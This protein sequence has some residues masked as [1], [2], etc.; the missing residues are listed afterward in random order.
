MSGNPF[1][2]QECGSVDFQL[3]NLHSL[4]STYCRPTVY[5][6]YRKS[7]YCVPVCLCENPSAYC[8]IRTGQ[9]SAHP[10]SPYLGISQ[11]IFKEPKSEFCDI[12]KILRNSAMSTTEYSHVN[13]AGKKKN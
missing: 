10:L 9:A 11:Q 6:H 7:H 5:S 4:P 8:Q 2:C 13:H 1:S 3:D 12:A